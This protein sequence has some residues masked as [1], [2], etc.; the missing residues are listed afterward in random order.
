MNT[1]IFKRILSLIAVSETGVGDKLSR[2]HI[3]QAFPSMR[4]KM[5]RSQIFSLNFNTCSYNKLIFP[6]ISH[7]LKL[8]PMLK[9]PAEQI[10]TLLLL[11]D[12]LRTD[13]NFVG[14]IYTS[15]VTTVKGKTY[16]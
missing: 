7:A 12:N 13:V 1:L 6:G 3:Q 16:W 2:Y 5:N 9:I 4:L 11:M 14:C 10:I 15:E 8:L